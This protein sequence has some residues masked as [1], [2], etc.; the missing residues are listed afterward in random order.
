MLQLWWLFLQ[1]LV[2]G[3]VVNVQT[4]V[5]LPMKNCIEY[6]TKSVISCC[7]YAAGIYFNFQYILVNLYTHNFILL[8]L[9]FISA[10]L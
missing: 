9:A 7:W 3:N 5:I 4:W 6:L 1:I 8:G 2:N 10:L